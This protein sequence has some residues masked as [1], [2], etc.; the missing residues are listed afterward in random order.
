M[1]AEASEYGAR[2]AAA[3]TL[4]PA[5]RLWRRLTLDPEDLERRLARLAHLESES[6]ERVRG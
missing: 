6:D 1:K 4:D 3:V 5:D 2:R